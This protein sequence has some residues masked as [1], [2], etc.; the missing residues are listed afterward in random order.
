MLNFRNIRD[1]VTKNTYSFS[2][3]AAAINA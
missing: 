1:N 2:H 3:S